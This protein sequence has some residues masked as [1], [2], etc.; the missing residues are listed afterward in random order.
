MLLSSHYYLLLT[1][2]TTITTEIMSVLTSPLY[3]HHDGRPGH[4]SVAGRG[5]GQDADDV[6]PVGDEVT[7]GRQL[8]VVDRQHEPARQRQVRV[9][10]VVHLV[11]L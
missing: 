5:V 11:T 4:G 6:R 8:A 2:A 7:D 3:F 10:T 9:E 1:T